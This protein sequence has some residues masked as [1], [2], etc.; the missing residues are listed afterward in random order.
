MFSYCVAISTMSE[1]NLRCATDRGFI[2]CLSLMLS[3]SVFICSA[4]SGQMTIHSFA[5]D[6]HKAKVRGYSGMRPK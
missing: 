3:I 5:L 2:Q 6:D 1:E 4:L